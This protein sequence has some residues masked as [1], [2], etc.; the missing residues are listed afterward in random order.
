MLLATETRH[1]HPLLAILTFQGFSAKGLALENKYQ[2]TTHSLL[3]TF[4]PLQETVFVCT[5][6]TLK[7]LNDII[8][9]LRLCP[10]QYA[11]NISAPDVIFLH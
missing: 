6:L 5:R 9:Y 10:A 7:Q 4:V 1:L 8:F 11:S 3:G 2:P